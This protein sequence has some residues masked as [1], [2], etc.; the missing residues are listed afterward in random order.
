M[1]EGGWKKKATA[2]VTSD[3][4][5]K[6]FGK[7][8]SSTTANEEGRIS[9]I[10]WN[11]KKSRNPNAKDD[12]RIDA[13]YRFVVLLTRK[14]KSPFR[15]R[16]KLNVDAVHMGLGYR[17]K[18]GSSKVAVEEESLD[19]ITDPATHYEG[20]CEGI[21]RMSLGRMRK[22]GRLAKLSSVA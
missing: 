17:L 22:K 1:V 6:Y 16:L 3:E 15:I 10:W 20:D 19:L 13:N 11:A 12:A 14:S 7:G 4:T 18:G 8:C 21:S 2:E 9:R 5:S